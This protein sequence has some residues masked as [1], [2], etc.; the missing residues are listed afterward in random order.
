MLFLTKQGTSSGISHFAYSK[1]SVV[2]Y[3]FGTLNIYSLL[4]FMVLFPANLVKLVA[5]D[6]WHL[7]NFGSVF[8]K[9]ALKILQLYYEDA[10]YFHFF[11][12]GTLLYKELPQIVIYNNLILAENETSILSLPLLLFCFWISSPKFPFYF[13]QLVN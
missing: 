2:C 9:S 5:A 4:Q 6:T 12:F 1:S 7:E 8:A 10:F 11:I 3:L 13:S